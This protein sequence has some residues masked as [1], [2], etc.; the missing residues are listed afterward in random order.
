MSS[1]ESYTSASVTQSVASL[2]TT[3]FF[4]AKR[5]ERIYLFFDGLYRDRI[6][7]GCAHV[8]SQ[9]EPSGIITYGWLVYQTAELL[10]QGF[11]AHLNFTDAT[12]N[13][14]EYFA[15]I[16]GLE[17]LIDLGYADRPILISGD[18]KTVIDQM[19][20]LVRVT[21]EKM[22]PL[23]QYAK[24]LAKE[25]SQL[26][27]RWVPR[28]Y[29]RASDRLTRKALRQYRMQAGMKRTEPQEKSDC[30]S[31]EEECLSPLFDLSIFNNSFQYTQ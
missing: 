20:A 23:H 22:I 15:L 3:D 10:G 6:P 27:W 7:H 12:S 29:N 18:S 24:K 17:A 25:F 2:N 4:Y 13:A 26:E 14:A 19:Q 21:S 30:V 1:F 9:E 5:P 11:G 28:K 16:H 31:I 8:Q